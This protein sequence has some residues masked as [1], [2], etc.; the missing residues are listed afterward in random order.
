MA[1]PILNTQQI[2]KDGRFLR[3][4]IWTTFLVT[5]IF[6]IIKY[7][8]LLTVSDFLTYQLSLFG[9]VSYFFFIINL[10]TALLI[11]F[12]VWFGK[13]KILW[14]E[15]ALLIP[16]VLLLLLHF[17]ARILFLFVIAIALTGSR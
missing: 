14:F 13:S 5:D 6:L 2:Q 1:N 8:V 11:L 16:G 12:K 9:N 15:V 10:L 3:R 17:A 7:P 4:I